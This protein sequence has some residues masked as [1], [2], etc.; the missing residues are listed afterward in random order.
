MKEVVQAIHQSEVRQ[1][2]ANLGLLADLEAGH[3]SCHVCNDVL[4]VESFRAAA[5]QSGVLHFCCGKEP[6][7]LALSVLGRGH[8]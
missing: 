6:C 1:F 7:L 2:L 4:T 8:A 3:I 5:R